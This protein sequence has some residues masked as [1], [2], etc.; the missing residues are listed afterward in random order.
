MQWN[1]VQ[2]LRKIYMKAMD[3]YYSEGNFEKALILLG[4]KV[5]SCGKREIQQH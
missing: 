1:D 2:I 3:Y 4:E 5:S